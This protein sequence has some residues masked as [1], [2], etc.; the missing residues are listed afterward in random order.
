MMFSITIPFYNEENNAENVVED[1]VKTLNKNRIVYELILVINGSLDNTPSIIKKLHKKHKKTKVVEVYPNAG[2]GGG[3]M[4]GM[5]ASKGDAV[6]YMCGDGQTSSQTLIDV[7]RKFE[8]ENLDFCQVKRIKRDDGLKRMFLSKC[9]NF[10]YHFLFNIPTSDIGGNPKV[11]KRS[12]FEK[13]DIQSKNFSIE[14][15]ILV[16]LG[17]LDA[18]VGETPVE[19]KKRQH[20]KSNI[21][22]STIYEFTKNAIKY[23]LNGW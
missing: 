13:L 5:K 14:T 4:H 19:F 21:K 9:F 1:L 10:M 17:K 15:E 3:I 23:K 12:V 7:I 8:N 2:F 22:F 11:M 18:R 6:G 20:G 16:K